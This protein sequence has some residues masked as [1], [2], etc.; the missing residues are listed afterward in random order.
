[1][2][3]LKKLFPFS[4][5]LTGDVVK[6][7]ISIIIYVVIGV[8]GGLLIGLLAGVAHIGFLFVILGT[9]LDLYTLIGII[10]AILNFFKIV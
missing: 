4:F 3:S 1:M 2:S 5:G 10:L 9:L 7:I 8:I 6:L